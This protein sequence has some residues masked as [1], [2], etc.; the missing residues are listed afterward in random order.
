[1]IRPWPRLATEKVFRSRIFELRRDIVRSPRLGAEQEVLVLETG[2]WVNIIPLTDDGQVVLIRQWRHGTRSLTLE[3]PGGLVDPGDAGPEAAALR[4]LREETGYEAARVRHLGTVEP[5]PAIF[6]NVC[7]TFLAEGVRPAADQDLD[8]GEDI[9][10]E[11][12]PLSAIPGLIA[13]GEIRHSL[14]VAAF[15]HLDHLVGVGR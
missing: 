4:E 11:L 2:D 3:V 12:R 15:Y 6:N 14:V 7:H 10:V 9:E 8:H 13:S 5:N 1:M